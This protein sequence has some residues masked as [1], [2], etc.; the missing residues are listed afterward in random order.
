[1]AHKKTVVVLSVIAGVIAVLIIAFS[2]IMNVVDGKIEEEISAQIDSAI[3]REGLGQNF[4]YGEV[5]SRAAQG[6][7]VLTEVRFSS[8][9]GDSDIQ[10]DTIRL[11]IPVTEAV[12]LI[13]N[14][15]SASLSKIGLSGEK[16]VLS[17][18]LTG[19]KT[20]TG[21]VQFHLEGDL[22]QSLM[23]APLSVLLEKISS[24]EM[25]ID[26]SRFTPGPEFLTQM[27]MFPGAATLVSDGAFDVKTMNVDV[28]ISPEKMAMKTL[29]VDSGLMSFD[30]S[31]DI[32]FDGEAAPGD[33]AGD[34][35]INRL[36]EDMRRSIEPFFQQ[37]GQPLP[38]EGSFDLG[39]HLP[40]GGSPEIT[41]K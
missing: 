21:A 31:A 17:N 28:D 36:H 4:S 6:R 30:G 13:Q 5:Q 23:N 26:D 16:L 33:F 22:D 11:S 10:A 34:F 27:Q 32:G 41:V 25:R 35:T 7:V 14:S 8:P 15:R 24:I 37:I 18:L 39:I 2:V 29:N 20:E 12:G 19:N 38:E 3:E 9:K 1:V 40:K